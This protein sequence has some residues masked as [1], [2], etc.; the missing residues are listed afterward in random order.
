MKMLRRLLLW[1]LLSVPLGTVVGTLLA[2]A[3]TDSGSYLRGSVMVSGG[4]IGAELGILGGAM[5]AL[6]TTVFGGVLRRAG[7]S[8]FLTGLVVAGGLMALGFSLVYL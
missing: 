3:D 5:A 8:A 2:Y 4:I 7:G 6:T 1:L